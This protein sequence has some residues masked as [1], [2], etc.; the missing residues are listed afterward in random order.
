MKE[1]C[2]FSCWKMLG[3]LAFRLVSMPSSKMSPGM[4]SSSELD[5]ERGW[6]WGRWGASLR[7]KSSF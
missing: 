5:S 1:V 6:I 7:E 3:T 4:K 2:G